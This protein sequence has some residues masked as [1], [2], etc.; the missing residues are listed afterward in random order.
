MLENNNPAETAHEALSNPPTPNA[1]RLLSERYTS[2]QQIF[3]NKRIGV[4]NME[5]YRKGDSY[6]PLLNIFSEEGG[7][8]AIMKVSAFTRPELQLIYQ[9]VQEYIKLLVHWPK[10]PVQVHT[11]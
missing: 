1:L 8:E 2:S 4:A 10:S 11:S 9:I 7:Q 6:N 3:D 5:T